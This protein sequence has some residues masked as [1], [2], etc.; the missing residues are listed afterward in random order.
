MLVPLKQ[1][2]YQEPLSSDTFLQQPTDERFIF[3]S[4]QIHDGSYSP[5]L[6]A[7]LLRPMLK[8]LDRF[9]PQRVIVVAVHKRNAEFA[10]VL[11]AFVFASQ[12]LLCREN[13]WVEI[14]NRRCVSVLRQPFKNGA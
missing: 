11:L 13:V 5:G 2:R 6:A 12:I 10:A 14:K 4:I 3:N 8:P 1:A 7:Q 9:A